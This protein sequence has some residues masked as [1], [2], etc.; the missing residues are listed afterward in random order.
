MHH[1]FKSV[2][3]ALSVLVLALGALGSSA[4]LAARSEPWEIDDNLRAQVVR[5]EL[6]QKR[7]TAGSRDTR[8][9][10]ADSA[11]GNVDIGNDESSRRAGQLDRNRP[12]II[13]GD[14]INAAQCR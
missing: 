1:S 5:E 8:T 3:R 6:R 13:T 4:A 7:E 14:V 10:R 12:I 11:C 9:G 2:S